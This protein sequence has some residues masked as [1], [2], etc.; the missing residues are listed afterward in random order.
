[1]S[2]K[3]TIDDVRV[4][5]GEGIMR[6]LEELYPVCDSKDERDKILINLWYS[7]NQ[8]LGCNLDEYCQERGR[9]YLESELI[10]LVQ[11]NLG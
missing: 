4:A 8:T 1:M 11:G 5:A 10:S 7:P 6:V 3:K 9:D 2:G